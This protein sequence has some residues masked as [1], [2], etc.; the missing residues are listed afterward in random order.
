MSNRYL[1]FALHSIGSLVTTLKKL[2]NNCILEWQLG[3]IAKPFNIDSSVEFRTPKQISISKDCTFKKNSVFNGRSDYEKFGLNF[4]ENTYFKENCYVDSYGGFVKIAGKCAFGQNT[5]MHGGGGIE[6]GEYVIFG[7]NCYIVSSNHNYKSRE[8]PIM[9]QGDYR[10]GITIG[11][12]VWL[13]GNVIVL[14]GVTIGD[15][16]VIGAGTVVTRSI[17]NN[18]KLINKN[19]YNFENIYNE[20]NN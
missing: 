19:N 18:T 4:G 1:G 2:S 11:N 17:P 7:A 5:N 10:K 16:C 20:E 14:D 13:G 6:I 15:N 12:N 9:L 3:S 8:L